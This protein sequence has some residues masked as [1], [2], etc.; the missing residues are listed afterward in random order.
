L[1]IE[2]GAT[3]EGKTPAIFAE[4][5]TSTLRQPGKELHIFQFI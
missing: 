2:E 4:S 5:G 3:N 1:L